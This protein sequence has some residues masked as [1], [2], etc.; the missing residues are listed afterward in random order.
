MSGIGYVVKT[1]VVKT[2]QGTAAEVAQECAITGIRETPTADVQTT[3]TACPDGVLTDTGPTSWTVD[4]SYNTSLK[5]DSF[6]RLLL[7]HVGEEVTLT[8]EPDPVGDPGRKRS[9][10]V[11]LVAPAADYTVGSWANATV[12]LPVQGTISTVDP[13]AP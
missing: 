3:Q 8:Y 9:A 13:A 5:P 12:S 10:T 11:K 6:H 4:V 2:K 1:M 7:D